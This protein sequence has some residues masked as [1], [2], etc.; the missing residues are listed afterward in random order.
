MSPSLCKPAS[1]KILDGLR[2]KCLHKIFPHYYSAVHVPLETLFLAFRF[3]NNCFSPLGL[4]TWKKKSHGVDFLIFVLFVIVLRVQCRNQKVNLGQYFCRR[5]AARYLCLKGFCQNRV[6]LCQ[7]AE[8]Q[9]FF[10]ATQVSL[11]N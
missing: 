9:F 10:L 11:S 1:L 5:R 6:N 3:R 4:R 7:E 2:N 8:K